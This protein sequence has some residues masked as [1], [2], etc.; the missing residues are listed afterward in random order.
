M[1]DLISVPETSSFVK[2]DKIEFKAMP[3]MPKVI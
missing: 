1:D 3:K 2:C